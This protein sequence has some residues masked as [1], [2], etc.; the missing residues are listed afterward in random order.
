M[1]SV[2]IHPLRTLD[3]DPTKR[4]PRYLDVVLSVP[5]HSCGNHNRDITI[6]PKVRMPQLGSKVY[7]K[8]LQSDLCISDQLSF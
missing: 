5:Y 7:D 3:T 6:C 1:D 8:A 4:L 2:T